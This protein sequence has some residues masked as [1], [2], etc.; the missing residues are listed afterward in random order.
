MGSL[1]D[2]V[3]DSFVKSACKSLY[4]VFK[5]ANIILPIS[6]LPLSTTWNILYKSYDESAEPPNVVGASQSD[7]VVLNNL[8]SFKILHLKN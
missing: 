6:L 4:K 1:A 2:A 5:S 7:V 8:K 3:N